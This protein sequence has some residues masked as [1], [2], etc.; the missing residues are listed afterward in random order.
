MERSTRLVICDVDGTLVG[1]NRMLSPA[2]RQVI[3]QLRQQGIY[4]GIASGRPVSEVETL[5]ERWQIQEPFDVVIGMNGAELWDGIHGDFSDYFKLKPEWIKE[6]ME[7]MAPFDL[8]ACIYKDEGMLCQREDEMTLQSVRRSGKKI[9]IAQSNEEFYAQ[10]NAKIM[11]RTTPDRLDAAEK[12]AK[13]HP[14]SFYKAFRTGPF[15]LEFADRRISKA[16][17]LKKFCEKHHFQMEEVLAFG[18]TSNDNEMLKASGWGVCLCNGSEDTK[19]AAN[20]IT[21][22]SNNEDGFAWYMKQ[23]FFNG[24]IEESQLKYDL[25]G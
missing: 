2:A 19:A 18:D 25:H 9:Q 24:R 8:N 20:A 21:E 11:F 12:Y 17:A 10:A 1:N 3:D 16:Y 14:S 23:H 6:I 5:L 13:E 7:L 15:I 4:F 22:K